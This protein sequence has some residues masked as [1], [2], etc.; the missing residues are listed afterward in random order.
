MIPITS[1]QST[2]ID[3]MPN[4]MQVRSIAFLNREGAAFLAAGDFDTASNMFFHGL[5]LL[6]IEGG[7]QASPEVASAYLAQSFPFDDSR[8]MRPHAPAC[9][10]S[11][12]AKD[13][14]SY[15]VYTN[16]L[17]LHPDISLASDCSIHCAAVL[18]FNMALAFHQRGRLADYRALLRARR[19]YEMCLEMITRTTCELLCTNV[20]V[21]AINNKAHIQFECSDTGDAKSTLHE[22]LIVLSSKFSKPQFE[23][24]EIE[25]FYL[26][27]FFLNT[28]NMAG[29]A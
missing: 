21:A 24:L 13:D 5:E 4:S 25:K 20:H 2:S 26:N 7:L 23:E 28:T 9:R 17:L 3:I 22:L 11:S 29:A 15:F 14:S 10:L 8:A 1:T 12:I 27:I 6:S 16:P 18:L 19:L